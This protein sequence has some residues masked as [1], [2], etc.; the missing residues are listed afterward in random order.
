MVISIYITRILS[1]IEQKPLYIFKRTMNLEG[2]N[3]IIL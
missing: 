3:E 2:K 1:E